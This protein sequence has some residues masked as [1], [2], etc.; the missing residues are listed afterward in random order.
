VKARTRFSTM[1]SEDGPMPFVGGGAVFY[2]H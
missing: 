2:W 1:T